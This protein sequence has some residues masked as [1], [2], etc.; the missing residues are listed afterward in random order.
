MHVGQQSIQTD[1]ISPDL[2]LGPNLSVDWNEISLSRDLN[3]V[4]A[5]IE[6]RRHPGP[7][8]ACEGIDR[9]LHVF[10]ADVL[11]EVDVEF[12]STK[13]VSERASIPDR[14]RKRRAGI[15]IVCISDDQRHPCGCL[16]R[17][18][19][20]RQQSKSDCEAQPEN[21]PHVHC[22][23]FVPRGPTCQNADPISEQPFCSTTRLRSRRGDRELQRPRH[24]RK[25]EHARHAMQSYYPYG[26]LRTTAMEKWTKPQSTSGLGISGQDRR[27]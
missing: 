15:R 7:D 11:L 19:R 16:L 25:Q 18:C 5:E 3:P 26:W 21:E 14:G 20:T 23:P 2:G 17:Q 6:Q 22:A 4:S 1:A 13:L 10:P 9:T 12:T 8:L 27:P 24:H